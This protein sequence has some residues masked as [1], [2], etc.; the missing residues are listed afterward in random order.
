MLHDALPLVTTLHIEKASQLRA[1]TVSNHLR[2]VRS[3]SICNLF[4][5]NSIGEAT[6]I[7][8]HIATQSVPFI[9]KRFPHLESVSFWGADGDNL[10]SLDLSVDNPDG[11][12]QLFDSFSSAFDCRSIPN[13]LQINGLRCPQSLFANTGDCKVCKRVCKMFPLERIGD[14]DLCLPIATS[15][16]LIMSRRG[17][18][19]YLQSEIRFMQLL[20]TFFPY[21]PSDFCLVGYDEVQDELDSIITSSKFDVTKISQE[22]MLIAITRHFPDNISVYLHE[23]SFDYLK[24]T[25]GLP[26]SN[27][28]LDPDA[29]RVENLDRM[30]EHIMEETSSLQKSMNQMKSLLQLEGQDSLIQRVTESG[31]LP[32]LIEFLQ[33]DNDNDLQLAAI[34]I[35]AISGTSEHDIEIVELGAIPP[36]VHLLSSSR[37]EIPLEAA[38]A[39]G[40][41]AAGSPDNRDLVLQ[42]RAMQPLLKLLK[43]HQTIEIN[44]VRDYTWVFSTLCEGMYLK[45]HPDFK[46]ASRSLSI[47]SELVHH[48]DD[49]VVAY[50]CWALSR[51]SQGDTTA[52]WGF[53]GRIRTSAAGIQSMID[54]GVIPKVILLL[55][56]HKRPVIRKT[57]ILA[58]ANMTLR[59]SMK[60]IKYFVDQGCIAPL[61]DLLVEEDVGSVRYALRAFRTVS[62]V[63]IFV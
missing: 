54:I 28:L 38:L 9:S 40:N 10:L 60:Q 57:A 58:F 8:E 34:D 30:V 53:W 20:G 19:D 11:I 31:V 22:D 6:E 48:R 18:R 24:K 59:G 52:L 23:D 62:K 47:L 2:D 17:G 3:I 16:E 27:D 21:V 26:I 14:I 51:L 61:L 63:E 44:S 39:L 42:A 50:A 13:N 41:I 35:M 4:R 1:G 46:L 55:D 56:K 29:V 7:D 36:L 5:T 32:K 37:S 15:K 49:Q 33:R 12:Y 45:K 43:D 25:I